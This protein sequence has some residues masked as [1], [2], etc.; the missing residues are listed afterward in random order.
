MC[1]RAATVSVLIPPPQSS[2][3]GGGRATYPSDVYS[4]GVVKYELLTER[5]PF[6]LTR[7]SSFRGGL[8]EA[9]PGPVP[10]SC[11]PRLKVRVCACACACVCVCVA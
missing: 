6:K 2:V 7:S 1:V 5:K 11:P 8:V 3:A 4:L 9:P 10:K